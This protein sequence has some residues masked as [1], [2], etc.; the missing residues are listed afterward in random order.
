LKIDEKGTDNRNI[1]FF[2]EA[3]ALLPEIPFVTIGMETIL[4]G[5]LDR[6]PPVE[7]VRILI[8]DA[9]TEEGEG[10]AGADAGS[11]SD[12]ARTLAGTAGMTPFKGGLRIGG[13][14]TLRDADDT[15]VED[16]EGGGGGGALPGAVG[17]GGT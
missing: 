5:G 9:V 6:E 8:C 16:L 4:L 11:D 12:W 7:A 14:G 3:S 17:G 2:L 13:G 10:G 15:I 1:L